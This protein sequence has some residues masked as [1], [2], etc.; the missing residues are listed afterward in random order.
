MS[1]AGRKIANVRIIRRA[2]N[3]RDSSLH[4]FRADHH[5]LEVAL[6]GNR[7]MHEV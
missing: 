3:I 6:S 4:L 1:R 2:A 7:L 5:V